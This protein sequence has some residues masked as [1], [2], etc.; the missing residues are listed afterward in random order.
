MSLVLAS[1]GILFFVYNLIKAIA[2]SRLN[3]FSGFRRAQ[4]VLSYI[5][6]VALGVD[7]AIGTYVVFWFCIN[8]QPLP[9]YT[10]YEMLT[11]V[12]KSILSGFGMA[13]Y[14]VV[15][16]L[17]AKVVLLAI[18]CVISCKDNGAYQRSNISDV[19]AMLI[20]RNEIGIAALKETY[21][22]LCRQMIVFDELVEVLHLHGTHRVSRSQLDKIE[23]GE[24]WEVLSSIKL[25]ITKD[26]L[27]SLFRLDGILYLASKTQYKIDL[28]LGDMH[29]D[30]PKHLSKNI[31]AEKLLFEAAKIDKE[32]LDKVNNLEVKFVCPFEKVGHTKVHIDEPTLMRFI[33]MVETSLT[34]GNN[35]KEAYK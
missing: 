13:T 1:I 9:E 8:Q 11:T 34:L 32:V 30:I 14:I 28:V 17:L 23:R 2:K 20:E 18:E 3:E 16:I 35:K 7:L 19:E 25:P 29:K 26:G 6:G 4:L 10:V 5:T 22:T 15:V 33:S 27:S 24:F 21:Q 12:G 31:D